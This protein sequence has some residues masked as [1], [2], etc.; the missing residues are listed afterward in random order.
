MRFVHISDLH[1][2]DGADHARTIEA[3]CVDIKRA[4]N[5]K[6]IDAILC[7]GDI[8]NRG[9]TSAA[10]IELQ[11]SVVRKI[12]NSTASAK[13]MCCPGNHDVNLKVRDAFFEPIFSSL[14]NPE[15]ANR[16]VEKVLSNGNTDF[17]AHFDGYIELS[18][19]LNPSAYAENPLFTT[20]VL[21]IGNH[22]VGIACLNSTW[23]TFGGGNKDKNNLYVGER[24]VELAVQ[25]VQHCDVKIALMHHTL[26]WLVQEEKNRIQRVLAY[27]FDAVLC[28]H[29]HNN[30]AGH[31]TSTLG[32]L[33]VSNT[34][35]IYESREYYNGYSILDV[36]VD[37]GRWRIEAREYYHE[38]NVFDISPRFAAGGF[39]EFENLGGGRASKTVVPSVAITAAL[40]KANSKLLSFSASEVAPKHLSSIFVEPP[41]AKRS[42]KNVVARK[43]L[44]SKGPQEFVSLHELSQE[45]IDILFIGKR[46]SGKSTLLNYIAVNMFM[47]FHGAARVGLLIDLST[48]SKVTIAAIVTQAIE[49]LGNEITKKDLVSLLENGEALVIFDS[50]NIH[51]VAHRKVIDEFREK[52]PQPRYILATNEEV[53][54]DLSLEKLPELKNNPVAIYIHSFKRKQTKEL[55][56]KWF[57]DHEQ[58]S[59]EKFAL[60]KKLLQRLNVPE[61]PF[62]VSVL[63]WVIEQQPRAK[64]INQ[65][66]AIEALI[67]GLLEKFTE[68]KSRSNYDSNIQSHFLTELSTA[69]D[70]SNTEWMETNEFEIF[71]SSYFKKRGLADPSRGF[72]DELLR[73]GLIYED[74]KKITFKF[75]C[76]RAYFLANKLA[77]NN[78]RLSRVLTP[79][80]I[81][82]YTA[83][84]DLLTGLHRDRKE[85]LSMARRCCEELLPG[86]EFEADLSLFEAHGKIQGFF[87]QEEALTQ[88]EDDFLSNSVDENHRAKYI[89]EVEIPSEA[90]IDHSHSRVRQSTA[91][92]SSQ[93]QF[94][95]ALKVYS[96]ILRNSEL[97]DD[98]DLK[99]SC[100][101]D[102]LVMWSKIIVSTTEFLNCADA[103]DLPEELPTHFGELGSDQFRVFVRLMI[104]QLVSALMAESLATPKLEAFIL[105]ETK[106]PLQCVRFLSTMLAIENFNGSSIQAIQVL[107]RDNSA[108]N[109]ILQA[110]FLRLLT[111]YYFEAP[112]HSLSALKECIGD[113]F[114]ALRGS[115]KQERTIIKGRFLQHI[116]ERRPDGFEDFEVD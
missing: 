41:L 23:R 32:D 59:E 85:I 52:Y 30:N 88:M 81:A 82:K 11:E 3:L 47:E 26:D 60:V 38:R 16:I 51:N 31:T 54:D 8:A 43:N 111:L 62:L 35:C 6:S 63:L 89:E 108:N 106:N 61:T 77:E 40:E 90:S 72:T 80:L 100:L 65:A 4:D 110:V 102:V 44:K 36:V 10:A 34:G 66:S 46:E 12:I 20:F 79:G 73:K 5:E 19:R 13:F 103:H 14:K 104:P 105:K 15:D 107:L 92:L 95:G 29:N 67:Y 55:V 109:I 57:G 99:E 53:Q 50:F 33:L 48:L 1:I 114:S 9:D 7:T 91:P 56:A 18:R 17:W 58:H 24:Q 76:F 113:A 25:E 28:G 2:C 22:K 69:M 86:S 75:D 93:M 21:E 49:F 71:V 42:E 27:N 83:E 84:L 87:N 74:N 115:S 39:Y 78:E 112:T 96:N 97:I 45:K 37:E 101:K 94:I 68:S 64:L 70:E 116:D 98:V